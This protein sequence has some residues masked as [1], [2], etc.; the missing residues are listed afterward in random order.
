MS[1]IMRQFTIASNAQEDL[2]L[3]LGVHRILAEGNDRETTGP[4]ITLH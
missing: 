4:Y 2:K 1:V 3:W